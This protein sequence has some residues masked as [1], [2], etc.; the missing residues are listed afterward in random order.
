MLTI[1]STK[2]ISDTKRIGDKLT[3]KGV[4]AEFETTASTKDSAGT[5]SLASV[6]EINPFLFL[7][8]IDEYKEDQ[9]RLKESGEQILK[10][11]NDIKF[12][13]VNGEL[14]A[15]HMLNLKNALEKNRKKF[16]FLQL[17]EV[18]DDIIIRAEVELAKLELGRKGTEEL[19]DH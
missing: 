9:Q 5:S 8:E 12:G 6:P 10:C 17:Q 1:N 13:L 4:T 2:S 3:K 16:K 18:I 11:L 14:N 15:G 19:E 7:Q